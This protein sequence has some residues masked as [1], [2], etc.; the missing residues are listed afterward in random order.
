M[1][2]ELNLCAAITKKGNNCNRK[3]FG[4]NTMCKQHIN[5]TIKENEKATLKIQQNNSVN[6]FLEK[7]KQE[8]L[9]IKAKQGTDEQRNKFKADILKAWNAEMPI[10]TESSDSYNGYNSDLDIEEDGVGI[11]SVCNKT[12]Y[13]VK[14]NHGQVYCVDNDCCDKDY[15][16]FYDHPSNYPKEI[17]DEYRNM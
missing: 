16:W 6:E 8:R 2:S 15:T 1:N 17:P 4:D 5:I 13:C 7:C 12:N 3:V 10:L 9:M 11:C 14:V